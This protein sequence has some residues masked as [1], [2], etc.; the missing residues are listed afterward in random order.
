M[1]KTIDKE[2]E[3]GS[4]R[5]GKNH[6]RFDGVG[7]ARCDRDWRRLGTHAQR[8]IGEGLVSLFAEQLLAPNRT[9]RRRSCKVH[10]VRKA[11]PVPSAPGQSLRFQV[12]WSQRT[13]T[14]VPSLGPCPEI[15]TRLRESCMAT[16]I[17]SPHP[18]RPEGQGE[19]T[20]IAPIMAKNQRGS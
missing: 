13:S 20:R 1:G 15:C 3:G 14:D 7:R 10:G 5:H 12:L 16:G 6:G 11:T 8:G 4:L 19:G 17:W 2:G 18:H 9:A